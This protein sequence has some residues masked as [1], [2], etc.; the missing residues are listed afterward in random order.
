MGL[1]V[2]AIF[3]IVQTVKTVGDTFLTAWTNAAQL[4]LN[5][6]NY[7]ATANTMVT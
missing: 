5:N 6:T 4:G 3:V 1:L 2:L 7:N